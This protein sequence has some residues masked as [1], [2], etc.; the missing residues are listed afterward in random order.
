MNQNTIDLKQMLFL[1]HDQK[2]IEA[3]FIL[4]EGCTIESEN[5]KPLIKVLNYLFN[6]MAQFT[7]QPMEI[8]LDLMSDSYRLTFLSFCDLQEEPAIS[9]QLADALNDYNAEFSMTNHAG[10]YLQLVI[11]FKR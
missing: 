4:D 7:E 3:N 5:P 6:F 10:Q 8:S 2:D 11:T 1:I 9:D